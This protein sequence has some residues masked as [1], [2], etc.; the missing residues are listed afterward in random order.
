M[1]KLLSQFTR[2][3]RPSRKTVRS[4]KRRIR[5]EQLEGRRLLTADL[6]DAFNS[7]PPHVVWAPDTPNAVIAEF[8]DSRGVIGLA[9][10]DVTAVD[11]TRWT[12]TATNGSGLAQGHATKLTW[13][14]VPDGTLLGSGAGEPNAPSNLRAFLNGLYG[15]SSNWLPVLQQAFDSW[16]AAT[17]IDFVY[18]SADDGASYSNANQGGLGVRGDIRL[19]G[20]AI[21]GNSGILAYNWYPNFGDMVIDTSDSFFS[22][23]SNNSLR[24]RNTLAHEIGHGIGLGHTLPSVGSKLMEPSLSLGF[25]GPQHDDILRANRGYGDRFEGNDSPSTARALGAVSSNQLVVGNLS[26]DDAADIDFFQFTVGASTQVNI[27]LDPIGFVYSVGAEG[28]ATETINSKA[29]SNLALTLYDSSGVNVIA[30]ASAGGLGASETL[31]GISLS[32]GQY[33]VRVTGAQNTAQ[34]YQLTLSSSTG[35]GDTTAPTVL[36]QTP[37]AGATIT[38]SAVNIDVR[39][40]EVVVGVDASDLVITGAGAVSAAVGQPLDLGSNTWR[41]PVSG[42]SNGAV[43]VSLAADANDIED[44]S[45]NDL[46]PSTWAYT[47]LL[48]TAQQ[49]PVLASIGDRSVTA[50]SA[51]SIALSATDPN[52]DPLTFSATANSVEYYLDQSLGLNSAGGNEYYNW[53]G[54]NEKWM[55]GTGGAWYYIKP[56]GQVYRWNGGAAANDLL[57]ETV[58]TAA[59]TNT[60]LLYNAQANN[61]PA[62]VVVNGSTLVVTANQGFTGKFYVTVSVSDGR[63]GSASETFKVAVQSGGASDTTPPTVL[64]YAPTNGQV[65][66]S[67]SVS[68]DVTFSEVVVGVDS[69][70]L[71]LTGAGAVNAVVGTAS[72]VSGNTW[73]FPVSALASGVV[74][75]TL[76]PDAQDIR[77]AAN[78]NL[79][80]FSWSFTVQLGSQ[81][82]PPV[83]ANIPNQTMPAGQTLRVALSASDPNG[84]PLTFAVSGQS[85]AYKLDQQLGLG[86]AGGN[87][88][89]NWG[90]K[91]EKWLTGS[92]GSWYYIT[93]DGSL[94]RWQ[95]GSLSSD[96][97]IALVGPSYYQNTALLYNAAANS[98]PASL[99]ISGNEVVIQPT[100]GFRGKFDVTVSVSDGQGGSDNKTFTVEVV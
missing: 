39:F 20:H 6:L 15:S 24:L 35:S 41:F 72:I 92:G 59:H 14:V 77:D 44:P 7:E 4:T 55:T 80:P 68:I 9:G 60:A 82:M 91:N 75:V 66:T 86:S 76:A 98:P 18:Q 57:V 13:S 1:F 83:L 78:N 81:P 79:A 50:G 51:S 96:P 61:A 28:S 30:N 11:G 71:Q 5:F 16:E 62:T 38:T 54:L 8:D 95:G 31:T 46:A 3:S 56:N 48:G 2:S 40:S 89:L 100:A 27:S 37:V 43:N 70:D 67:S 52:G 12:R 25:D 45:G 33:L 58:G 97:L 36:S 90:G 88:Y 74:Q 87:E 65:V 23:L 73:R 85:E 69:S 49:P 47:V 17:G 94:Y 64:S 10:G 63:G 29:L 53:L 22:S 42:L 21:D 32:A 19:A 26:I 93:P 34:M 84:D 99:G